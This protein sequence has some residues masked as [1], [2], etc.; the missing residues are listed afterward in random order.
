MHIK[1]DRL[2]LRPYK[3][4]DLVDYYELNADPRLLTYELHKPF[5]MRET[6][7]NLS[8]WMQLADEQDAQARTY[9]IGGNKTNNLNIGIYEVGIEL[10]AEKRLI[11][12]FSSRFTDIG[13]SVLEIGLRV[14]FDFHGQGYGTE[15]LKTVIKHVFENTDIHRIFGCTDA[16]NQAC[17]KVFENVGMQFEGRLRQN[18]RLPDDTYADEMV[19]SILKEKNEK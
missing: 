15:A 7:R 12:L 4:D 16:R 1:T 19:Y 14:H 13:S 6:K 9:K 10:V 8:Y 18:I 5:D 3:R 17:I 2:L 11:G